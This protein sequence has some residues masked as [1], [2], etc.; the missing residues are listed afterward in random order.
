[1]HAVFALI[2][3]LFFATPLTAANEGILVVGGTGQLGSYHVKSLSRAGERVVVLAR[4]SSTFE[5]IEGS[6]YEVVIGDLTD[7]EG[8]KAAVMEARP[9]IIIDAANIPG[10][11]MD[12]GDSFY[13]VAAQN[14]IAAARAAGVSQVI[15]HGAGGARS[16]LTQVPE[17]F[18]DEP[19][20]VNYMRDRARAE[21]E[22]E[23][24]GI[25]WTLVHNRNL[26]PEPAEATGGG[27]LGATITD[28]GPI[29]RADLA[30][31]ANRCILNEDCFNKTFYAF[32]P[33]RRAK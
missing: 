3:T 32:D 9:A 19:R 23:N 6:D 24:S 8:L 14:L 15:V 28:L 30:A 7:A 33:E 27:Q 17:M 26:P 2:A 31:A 16:M 5:R 21:M 11:R 25:P 10:I 22:W 12:D 18:A 13:Q 4:P 1:M 29:A 20:I